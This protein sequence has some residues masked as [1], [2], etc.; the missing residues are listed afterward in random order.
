[1]ITI[2]SVAVQN[3]RIED[4]TFY[5]DTTNVISVIHIAVFM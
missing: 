2:T 1:M 4:G 5:I 3:N